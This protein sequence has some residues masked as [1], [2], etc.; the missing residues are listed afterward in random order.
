MPHNIHVLYIDD[1]PANLDTVTR[2]L[3]RQGHIVL[4]AKTGQAGI[5]IAERE[6]PDII[7]LDILLPD[8]NGFEVCEQ[9]RS[10]PRLKKIPIRGISAST[11]DGERRRSLSTGFDGFLAKPIARLDLL[12]AIERLVY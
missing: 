8:M 6:R 9:L 7:L 4:V 1:D 3:S 5:E 10:K 12:N 11:M 2:A